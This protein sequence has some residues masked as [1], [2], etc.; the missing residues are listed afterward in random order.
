MKTAKWIILGLLTFGACGDPASKAPQEC[1]PQGARCTESPCCGRFT[2]DHDLC[3]GAMNLNCA[4][5]ACSGTQPCC[6]GA[7]CFLHG[8]SGYCMD[9]SCGFAGAACS[10]WA[11]CC[12]PLT[13]PRSADKRCQY[14]GIGD[15]CLHGANCTKGLQCT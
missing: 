12:A 14:G 3:V 6:S 9:N 13:C 15:S 8:D 7:I 4:G 2:C 5:R 1:S 11:D 10:S